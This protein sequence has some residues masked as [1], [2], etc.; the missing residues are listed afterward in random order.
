MAVNP[1]FFACSAKAAYFALA[2]VSPFQAAFRFSIVFG[3]AQKADP[4]R[5]NRQQVLRN[6]VFILQKITFMIQ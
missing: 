1:S 3:V 4:E 5:I 6:S 2:V